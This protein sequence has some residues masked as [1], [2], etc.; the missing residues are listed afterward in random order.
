MLDEPAS[1][2]TEQTSAAASYRTYPAG[3]DGA[4]VSSL[5][6]EVEM[7]GRVFPSSVWGHSVE[8]NLCL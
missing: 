4:F 8:T 6:N 3:A 7:P 1:A 2:T 5:G